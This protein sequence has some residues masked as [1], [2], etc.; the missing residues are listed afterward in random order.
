M[1]TSHL[2]HPL[3][4]LFALTV[5]QLPHPLLLD[6]QLDFLSLFVLDFEDVLWVVFA[7][8]SADENLVGGGTGVGFGYFGEDEGLPLLLFWIVD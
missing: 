7:A 3:L 4:Q 5:S 1:L 2:G 8:A 6:V